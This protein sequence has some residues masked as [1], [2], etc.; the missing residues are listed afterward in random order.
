MIE[1]QTY[2][3]SL[4]TTSRRLRFLRR[5]PN[6]ASGNWGRDYET[7]M[8]HAYEYALR[9]LLDEFHIKGDDWFQLMYGP[10]GEDSDD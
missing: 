7:G 3:A 10:Q 2:P 9:L 6:I 8:S 4:Q 5:H 1:T